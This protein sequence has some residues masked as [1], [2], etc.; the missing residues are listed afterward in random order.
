MTAN[1]KNAR[2]MKKIWKMSVNVINCQMMFKRKNK[3][4]YNLRVN[5]NFR[6]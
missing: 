5:V 6:K 1:K 2:S 3:I 4:K